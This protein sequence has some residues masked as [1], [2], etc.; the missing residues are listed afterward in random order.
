MSS[1]ADDRPP[2]VRRAVRLVATC[3]LLSG[4]AAVLALVALLHL[5]RAGPTYLE[6][7]DR[8]AGDPNVET[9]ESAVARIA[10]VHWSLAY[11]MVTG[12]VGLV[13]LATLTLVL[14]RPRRRARIATWIGTGI[15][16]LAIFVAA[17]GSTDLLV[18]SDPDQLQDVR[19]SLANLFPIWYPSLAGVVGFSEL[20]A[21]LVFTIFL[22]HHDSGEYYDGRGQDDDRLWH[23]PSAS[24]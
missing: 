9:H 10:D 3:A 13:V 12:I 24:R 11:D 6:V 15:L 17:A 2:Q 16:A 14:L 23:L 22:A 8:H 18:D 4:V 19:D 1:Q 7:I 20:A 21:M 5:G